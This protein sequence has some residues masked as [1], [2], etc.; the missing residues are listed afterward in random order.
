MDRLNYIK[1]CFHYRTSS[2]LTNELF[3][4]GSIESYESGKLHDMVESESFKQLIADIKTSDDINMFS[5][6]HVGKRLGIE[7]YDEQRRCRDIAYYVTGRDLSDIIDMNWLS[8][9]DEVM[10]HAFYLALDLKREVLA[11]M[12]SNLDVNNILKTARNIAD[13]NE[14]LYSWCR[15]NL[16]DDM[17]PDDIIGKIDIYNDGAYTEIRYGVDTL[18]FL[19]E[20]DE[21]WDLWFEMLLKLKY[22]PLQGWMLY[23]LKT[24]EEIQRIVHL[25]AESDDKNKKVLLWLLRER[26]FAIAT[27]ERM[28]LDRNSAC[29]VLNE[30]ESAI[31]K[32]EQESFSCK[33]MGIIADCY[34]LFLA[35]FGAIDNLNWYADKEFLSVNKSDK[36]RMADSF[37]LDIVDQLLTEGINPNTITFD[38]LS[39]NALLYAS[40]IL[41]AH[42]ADKC[43]SGGFVNILCEKLYNDQSFVM[44][45]L[46]DRQFGRMRCVYQCLQK[47]ELDGLELPNKYRLEERPNNE[48]TYLRIYRCQRGDSYWLSVLM[49]QAEKDEDSSLLDRVLCFILSLPAEDIEGPNDS[50]FMPLY[51]GEMVVSQLILQFKDEYEF[52]I[53]DSCCPV[54]MI[55][56]I[57]TA[58]KGEL[59][60]GVKQK[61]LCLIDEKWE[62][63]SKSLSRFDKKMYEYLQEYIEKVRM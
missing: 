3:T 7:N 2:N 50:Y 14:D 28:N 35:T 48:E 56:R 24:I 54:V 39:T 27:E 41:V 58:N 5:T 12:V 8:D 47:S 60:E 17:S 46:S 43:V 51:I 18:A 19:L 62:H 42:D 6:E 45:P 44:P 53:L 4:L 61:L 40:E 20:R 15:K 21:R 37:T 29:D 30:S 13:R 1:R 49:L 52:K 34:R 22:F 57:F 32:E 36:Y 9:K 16:N 33:F 55:I 31:L 10:D 23:D 11:E 38:S 26:L 25:V 63:D 59:S